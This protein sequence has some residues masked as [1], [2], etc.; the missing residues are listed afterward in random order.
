VPI[1]YADGYRRALSNRA[2][3]GIGGARTPV[4]GRVSMDQTVIGL[5]DEL[6]VAAGDEVTVAGGCGESGAPSIVELADL[7]ETIPYEVV[8]GLGARVPR[9]Y[10]AG[11]EL[12]TDVAD[13]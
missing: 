10:I 1:G 5:P 2:W 6:E 11:G 9:C 8:A 7:L 13:R 3:M 4:L 12:I